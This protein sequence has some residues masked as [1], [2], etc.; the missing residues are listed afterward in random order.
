MAEKTTKLIYIHL[1]IFVAVLLVGIGTFVLFQVAMPD[2]YYERPSV[3][4]FKL[5]VTES[6]HMDKLK[7]AAI[8]IYYMGEGFSESLEAVINLLLM[9]CLFVAVASLYSILVL[10]SFKAK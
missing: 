6:N 4:E 10:R 2:L 1:A 5:A 9:T 8:K 7:T 3:E